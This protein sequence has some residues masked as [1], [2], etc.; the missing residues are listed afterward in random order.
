MTC[1]PPW[2]SEPTGAHLS[3]GTAGRRFVRI[4]TDVAAVPKL[5]DYAVPE[6]WTETVTVGTRVRAV[7]HGRRVGGWV[8]E[9]NVT[10]PVGVTPTPLTQWSGWGPPA[11]VVELA[12]W[13][14][15][16]WAGPASFF[17]KAASPDH[18]V[19]TLPEVPEVPQ[20][21][22][23]KARRITPG[24]GDRSNVVSEL[25]LQVQSTQAGESHV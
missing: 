22:H 9:D 19:R 13:A 8:T 3:E 21:P 20:P 24:E 7:L 16:R 10:P 6:R 2:A 11:M 17:L 4:R 15:W 12:E 25:T 5:F 18:V 23:A 1:A 14:A